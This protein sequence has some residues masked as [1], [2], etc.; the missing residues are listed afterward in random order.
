MAV[1]KLTNDN[2]EKEIK[3]FEG[4]ALIDF[5]ADWC[6]PCKMVSPIVDAIAEEQDKF[7]IC[8]VNVDE[9][10]ELAAE[11]SVMSIPTLVVMK[12]GEV[13]NTH[14]GLAAKGKILTMLE[15]A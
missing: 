2:F 4:V 9:E 12:N 15:N 3:Q 13:A 7:K 10:S 14:I 8:K 5:Y 6:G 1:I 11:F